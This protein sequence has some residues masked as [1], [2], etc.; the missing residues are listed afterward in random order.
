MKDATRPK[1][2]VVDDEAQITRVLKTALSTQGYEVRAAGDGVAAIALFAE[3]HPDVVVTDI[4]MPEMDGVELCRELRATS[5]I[6][7]IVLSVRDQERK[8]I[9]A[10]DAGADDYVTKP[11]SIQELLARLRAQLRRASFS[12]AT[13]PDVLELGHFVI[14]SVQHRVTVHGEE[15]HLTPKQFELLRYFAQHPEQMLTHRVLLNAVWGG[16][17][18]EQPEHLRVAI[19]Q[20][21]KKIE[22]EAEPRYIVTE[23]WIGYK[24][25][26]G[27]SEHVSSPRE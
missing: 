13:Q 19:N 11:F 8:K 1:V 21:R 22:P 23:P 10:L 4:S 14:D 6:P 24:F 12:A 16:N 3:W 25:M 9:Q 26:P 17:A 27:G 18:V 5:E 7:I 15:V 20:L 2:L